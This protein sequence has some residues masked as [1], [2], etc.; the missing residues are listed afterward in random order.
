MW[1]RYTG[2][3]MLCSLAVTFCTDKRNIYADVYTKP[4]QWFNINLSSVHTQFC[5]KLEEKQPTPPL[6][7]LNAPLHLLRRDTCREEHYTINY[8]YCNF[9]VGMFCSAI[10]QCWW[11]LVEGSQPC[12]CLRTRLM[13]TYFSQNGQTVHLLD[14][15]LYY[16]RCPNI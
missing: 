12:M 4:S 3:L 10:P 16:F 7:L 8:Y 13:P 2:R 11:E 5:I 9:I 14:F 1:V 15:A 6:Q